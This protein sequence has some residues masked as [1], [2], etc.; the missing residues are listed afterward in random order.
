MGGC[1]GD[2]NVS[3]GGKNEGEEAEEDCMEVVEAAVGEESCTVAL[4]EEENSTD[5]LYC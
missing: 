4:V 1:C 2:H 5:R 3:C